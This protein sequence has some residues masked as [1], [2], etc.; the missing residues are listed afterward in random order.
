MLMGN[1]WE[2]RD[3]CNDVKLQQMKEKKNIKLIGY[4][5]NL[6]TKKKLQ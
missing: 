1:M 4:C 5:L 6:F 2:N 3:V